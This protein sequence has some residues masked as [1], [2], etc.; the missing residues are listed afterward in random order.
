MDTDLD[1]DL[2]LDLDNDRDTDLEQEGDGVLERDMVRDLP[3][4]TMFFAWWVTW[5][6]NVFTFFS[7]VAICLFSELHLSKFKS[8]HESNF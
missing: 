2:D 6:V 4:V 8:G 7:D 1:L 3:R 5:F